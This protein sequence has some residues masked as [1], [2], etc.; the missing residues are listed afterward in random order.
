MSKPIVRY[1]RNT[2]GRDLVVGDIKTQ[3]VVCAGLLI[4]ESTVDFEGQNLVMA[5]VLDPDR[6]ITRQPGEAVENL[7]P[8][9]RL[10]KIYEQ[11]VAKQK[12]DL[13]HSI[14]LIQAHGV[15][16]YLAMLEEAAP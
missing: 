6:M 15:E 10:G 11:I 13:N 14:G 4:V 8:T 5:D 3:V 1:E 7:F 9:E 12:D 16:G 2:A